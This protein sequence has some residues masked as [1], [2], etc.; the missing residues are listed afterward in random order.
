MKIDLNHFKLHL[1]IKQDVELTLHFNSPSRRFYLSV[2]GLVVH[3]MQKQ[4]RMISISMQDHIEVLQLLNDT[5]GGGAGSPKKSHLL[6]RIYM[7][8]KD[9][10]PDLENAPLFKIVGRKKSYNEVMERV[11]I[12]SEIEKDNWANLFEYKGS[13]ENV[14]LRFSLDRLGANLGD[15]VIVHGDTQESANTDPW[16]AFI[17]QL[18]KERK[19]RSLTEE[20]HQEVKSPEPRALQPKNGDKTSL[21][22]RQVAAICTIVGIVL[23]LGAL[24]AWKYNLFTPQGHGSTI[25]A[26][27]PPSH[28]KPSIAVLPFRNLSDDPKQEYFSDGLTDELIGDLAKVSDILVISRNSVF[29]YKG[30]QIKNTQ[31]ARELNVRYLLEGS[32][33]KS[34]EKVRIRA[35]LIDGM[36]D[37]HLWAESYDGLLNDI[38]DMQDRI[39]SEIVTELAIKLSPS[40]RNTITDKGTVNVFAYEAF[41]KGLKCFSKHT[42]QDFLKAI[43]YY[44]EAIN[45]DP[46]FG[47]AYAAIGVAYQAAGNYNWSKKMGIG[48][49]AMRLLSRKYLELAMKNPTAEAYSLAAAKEIHRRN[50][51][52][53]IAFAEK[54]L[55]YAPNSAGKI[56]SLAW[57]LSFVGEWEQSIELLDK[58]IRL[59]PIDTQNHTPICLIFI[60]V[61]HFCMG[62]LQEA[63]K[64]L[65]KGL[66]M[67]LELNNF[68]CFLAAS[69]AIAGND[70]KANKALTDYLKNFPKGFP[71]TIRLL[72]QAWPFKDSE[73]FQRLAQGLVKA[74]LPGDPDDYFEMNN[75]E[76]IDG[77]EIRNI[78]FG[79]T[80][81]GH[82]WGINP[83]KWSLNISDTGE[84]EFKRIEKTYSGK[85]WIE[86]DNLCLMIK[87]YQGDL[88]SCETIYRNLEG[89]SLTKTEYFRMSD[90]GLFLFSVEK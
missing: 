16:E 13:H 51:D 34:G 49:I 62:N 2:I 45:F 68:S 21:S 63:L 59:D 44:K 80:S 88:K 26:P 78:M 58:A 30:K 54:A 27:S 4:E 28:E 83:I 86:N 56:A 73:I 71:V 36:T 40:E 64:Y 77:M 82:I 72:Y 29:T 66:S 84:V 41:L 18:R 39:T 87:Q 43:E 70:I 8:W 75:K 85:A 24:T 37:L 89:D 42:P 65:E 31:I 47:R 1:H 25:E 57:K 69:Y 22:R 60:G 6:P 7:K 3:E 9:A 81:S 23:V 53:S 19:N 76:K 38:F 48:H 61:N 46:Y 33:Q 15:A 50:F 79:K 67:N 11:Y 52:K 55:E 90:Y 20:A 32:V 12:F 10:L 17:A 74:G 35:Q 5:V 14:R